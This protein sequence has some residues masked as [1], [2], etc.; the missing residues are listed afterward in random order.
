MHSS[1]VLRG[2]AGLLSRAHIL[3]KFPCAAAEQEQRD[4]T[5]MPGPVRGSSSDDQTTR[6]PLVLAA[7][8]Q[9]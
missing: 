2:E 6:R 5:T 7:W 4:V 9:R 1:A 3:Q 8:R